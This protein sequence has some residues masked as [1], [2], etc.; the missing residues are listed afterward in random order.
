SRMP[1]SASWMTGGIFVAL[2]LWMTPGCYGQELNCFQEEQKNV[3]EDKDKNCKVWAD[4]SGQ[5]QENAQWMLSNCRKACGRCDHFGVEDFNMAVFKEL[6]VNSNSSVF[7]SPYSL[8]SAFL[9]TYFGSEGTT[10]NQLEA[11]LGVRGK[12]ETHKEWKLLDFFLQKP[13]QQTGTTFRILNKAYF[14]TSVP[15]KKCISEL[16]YN[17]QELNF[18]DKQA[19]ADIINEEVRNTTEGMIPKLIKAKDLRAANFLLLNAVYFKGNW[20]TQF[21]SKYTE[22]RDFKSEQEKSSVL[23][24]VDMMFDPKRS[25]KLVKY[26][27][28]NAEIAEIPYDNSTISMILI[29]PYWDVATLDSVLSNLTSANLQD[30]M[31]QMVN[32]TVQLGIPKFRMETRI[33]R[34]L[35]KAMNVLGVTEIFSGRADLSGFSRVPLHVDKVIHEAVVEVTEEGT[36]AAAATAVLGT[37]FSYPQLA[38]NKPFIFLIHDKSA[39]VTLFAGTFRH[40]DDAK[41]LPTLRS[42]ILE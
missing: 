40:P 11:A 26:A 42:F 25:L 39:N 17:L 30:A 14:D 3:C 15:L 37:R 21:D 6:S 5:C 32:S 23:G 29:K 18:E 19:T 22:R 13:Y 35:V 12:K 1:L 7:M 2:L 10:K 20:E 31:S 36:R 38:M 9:L 33:E 8:W 24:K 16:I 41:P 34:D 4:E 27:P 28:L